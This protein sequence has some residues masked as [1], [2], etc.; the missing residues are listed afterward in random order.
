MP[1]RS[2]RL[3]RELGRGRQ[4]QTPSELATSWAGRFG[5]VTARAGSAAPS[6]GAAQPGLTR[7]IWPRCAGSAAARL[8]AHP[9]VVVL[10]V[11]LE[12]Q[13]PMIITGRPPRRRCRRPNPHGTRAARA[14]HARVTAAARHFAAARAPQLMSDRSASCQSRGRG[15]VAAV[16]RRGAAAH[17]ARRGEW[18]GLPALQGAKPD[19][20]PPPV[21]RA[22]SLRARL[23]RGLPI[24]RASSTR[25]SSRTTCRGRWTTLSARSATW[26]LPDALEHPQTLPYMAPEYAPCRERAATLLSRD[27]YAF[28]IVLNEMTGRPYFETQIA[29]LRLKPTSSRRRSRTSRATAIARGPAW[30]L[31]RRCWA[32]LEAPHDADRAPSSGMRTRA[33]RAGSRRG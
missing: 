19:T 26:H 20:L 22:A 10:A 18:D 25:T 30:A 5:A 6:R 15:H 21:H 11:S 32:A 29:G 2:S 24:C 4:L 16:R 33:G 14:R 7:S 1:R 31:A 8:P 28:G 27:V 17:G 12:V 3:R 13:N 23:S 9:H